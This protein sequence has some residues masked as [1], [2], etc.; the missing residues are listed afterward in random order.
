[1]QCSKPI[2]LVAA[3]LLLTSSVSALAQEPDSPPP[4]S[5]PP[6]GDHVLLG[7]GTIY[8]PSRQGSDNYRVLTLPAID[9]AKGRLFANLKDGV[10]F[11]LVQTPVLSVGTSVAVMPGFRQ[12]DVPKGIDSVGFGAGARVFANLRA[13]GLIAT[14]GAT[15]GF[16][17]STKGL[18]ADASIAY[19]ISVSPRLM[20]VPALSTSW[21]NGKH[22]DRYFGIDA[23]EAQ[24]SGLREYHPGSGFKDASISV[25]AN[26]RLNSRLSLGATV[27]V[28][29]LIGDVKNSPLTEKSTQ[30]L[31][32]LSMTYRL[33]P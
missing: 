20:V 27:G 24:A 7:I 33:S 25:S 31:A 8:M 9:I 2:K 28:T 14:I 6:P 15:Q 21:A 32:I 1:M 17:G 16:A 10:G 13:G 30:P 3:S 18:I 23:A 26:Y 22:N 29:T 4:A 11:N 12:R 19:P 5:G